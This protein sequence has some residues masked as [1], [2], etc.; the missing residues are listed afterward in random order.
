M[1]TRRTHKIGRL[2]FMLLCVS[3]RVSALEVTAVVTSYNS[4]ELKGD[5][6]YSMDATF[7]NSNHSKGNITAGNE[8]V[9][10]I[11]HLPEGAV[12]KVELGMKSNAKSGAGEVLVMLGN[13][14]I[15]KIEDSNF[16]DWPGVEGYST[17]VVPV[18]FEGNW[19]ME[20][21]D[22]LS[23]DIK[24]SVNTLTLETVS[25]TYMTAQPA[26]SVVTLSWLDANGSRKTSEV[27]ES[28][29]GQGVTLPQ[30]KVM[31]VGDGWTFAGW[32]KVK[33]TEEYTSKP[34]LLKDGEKFYPQADVTLYAV[35]QDN[36]QVTP[37]PQATT[38]ESGEYA[39]AAGISDYHL[40]TGEVTDKIVGGSPVE[41]EKG[42]NDI[43]YLSKGFV[44]EYSR[45]HLEFDGD[46][47][48][49]QYILTGSYVGHNSSTLTDKKA[50]WGWRETK[51]H[52]LEL[53]FGRYE[54]DGVPMA[55]VLWF[56]EPNKLFEATTMKLGYDFE[57]MLL[58][59][60]SNAPTA[61]EKRKWTSCPF[62]EE[63]A[64]EN[65]KE[66]RHGAEKFL[67]NG[68]LVIERDGEMYDIRG[69]KIEK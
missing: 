69:L 45:Y 39:I 64:V 13:K 14:Q 11:M 30:C 50:K 36:P 15:A 16:C 60:V 37:I 67:R 8:A 25:V 4:L 54:K 18:V 44:S 17:T 47:V 40:M 52:S 9:L 27:A 35:Y 12:T 59:E 41:L 66:T 34:S 43:Y 24:A 56:D 57:Y 46:T 62:G 23:V 51:N 29:A 42:E 19:K 26:P 6:T 49:I 3:L 5:L 2:L 55:R 20:E 1:I 53:S 7:N 31:E 38:F 58:F 48:T 65:V 10:T 61:S 22:D 33:I 32:S 63:Q 28:S 21:Y 68:V